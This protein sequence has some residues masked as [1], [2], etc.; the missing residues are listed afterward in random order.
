MLSEECLKFYSG[1]ELIALLHTFMKNNVI[2]DY[3]QVYYYKSMGK[4]MNRVE[5]VYISQDFSSDDK[6]KLLRLCESLPSLKKQLVIGLM[7]GELLKK[8]DKFDTVPLVDLYR[9]SYD[10][11]MLTDELLKKLQQGIIEQVHS[12][13]SEDVSKAAWL[14]TVTN[15]PNMPLLH[16]KIESIIEGG[17]NKYGIKDICV[18]VWSMSAANHN[19]EG[20]FWD[21]I[22][23]YLQEELRRAEKSGYEGMVI[24]LCSWVMWAY[25]NNRELSLQ[26]IDL[27]AGLII[28]RLDPL[29][30][31]SQLDSSQ[32]AEVTPFELTNIVGFFYSI[33][34]PSP[35]I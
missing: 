26:T 33:E 29:E 9:A 16:R 18:V 1:Q 20:K 10:S 11:G 25:L 5:L 21:N 4:I 24:N 27:L 30:F 28:E 7:Q 19:P 22:E 12:L 32:A 2:L 8:H 15:A 13:P 17:L 14:F 34:M 23:F 31:P 6:I 35:S 3:D